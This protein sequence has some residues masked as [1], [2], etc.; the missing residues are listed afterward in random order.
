MLGLQACTAACMQVLP[1]LLVMPRLLPPIHS[2]MMLG[3]GDV[4]V[5]G[6]L[7][8]ML[9][10]FD[11]ATGR[12]AGRHSYTL[13]T[14]AAYVVGL[15]LTDAALATRLGGSQGQPALLYLVPS[16]LGTTW[17]LAWLRGDTRVLWRGQVEEFKDHASGDDVVVTVPAE[18]GGS[19]GDTEALVQARETGSLEPC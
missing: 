10:R 16:T 8:M 1:M 13:W 7:I 17:L 9:R 11:I 3:Y 19:E 5:P 6:L 12:G 14:I 15:L 4:A 2:N 18:D